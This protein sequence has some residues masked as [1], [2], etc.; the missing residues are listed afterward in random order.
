MNTR[1]RGGKAGITAL[2]KELG[3]VGA[4]YFLRQFSTGQGDYTAERNTLLQGLTLDDIIKNVRE[5]D[6]QEA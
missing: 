6:E 4:T 1:L 5:I 2:Q 3:T